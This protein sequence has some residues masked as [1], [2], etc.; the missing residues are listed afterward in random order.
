MSENEREQSV[1]LTEEETKLVEEIAIL[2]PLEKKMDENSK[3]LLK[4]KL[5]NEYDSLYTP[6]THKFSK[7]QRVPWYWW[8]LGFSFAFLF[9]VFS[10]QVYQNTWIH[11]FTQET[12]NITQTDGKDST[13]TN[14]T[15]YQGGMNI[16]PMNPSDM[17][18][19]EWNSASDEGEVIFQIVQY[20]IYLS[21]IIFIPII[22][23]WIRR[24]RKKS[25]NSKD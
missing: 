23:I 16:R 7:S 1:V 15:P 5:L 10:L 2:K 24:K 9:W 12:P 4:N 19:L 21:L 13:P 8:G 20:C 14:F 17:S 18:A 22:F 3:Q 11:L 25:Q 6:R